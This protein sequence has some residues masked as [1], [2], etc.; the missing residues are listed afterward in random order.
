MLSSDVVTIVH[1]NVFLKLYNLPH[2]V[3]VVS[4]NIQTDH[5]Q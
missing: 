1:V 4:A 3:L 5:R 2:C